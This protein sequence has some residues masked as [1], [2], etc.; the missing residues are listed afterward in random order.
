MTLQLPAFVDDGQ[1]GTLTESELSARLEAQT[2]AAL[3]AQSDGSR[4]VT[5]PPSS[6][7]QH[8][9]TNAEIDQLHS[10]QVPVS[11]TDK[12]VFSPKGARRR[13]ECA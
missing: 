6:D 4:M 7:A 2:E 9:V 13:S 10:Q 5:L 3:Q 12:E 8:G 1:S 11:A